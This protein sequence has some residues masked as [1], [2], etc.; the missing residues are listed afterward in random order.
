MYEV[1]IIKALLPKGEDAIGYKRKL[2]EFVNGRPYSHLKGG[3]MNKKTD[4]S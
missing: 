2:L 1:L 3:K 4:T